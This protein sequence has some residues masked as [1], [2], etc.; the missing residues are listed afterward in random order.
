MLTGHAERGGL[1]A[2]FVAHLDVHGLGLHATAFHPA[3]VHAQKHVGPV[4]RLGAACS[5]VDGEEGGI[6]VEL[7]CEKLI[8]FEFLEIAHDGVVL[9]DDFRRGLSL[10]FR[11]SSAASSFRTSRSAARDSSCR[12]GWILLRSWRDFRDVAL[13][14]LAVIPEI[15]RRHA[16]FEFRELRCSVWVSQRNLRSSARRAETT[17]VSIDSRVADIDQ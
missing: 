13:C 8:E 2:G 4:A 11:A 10:V 5:G 7:A 15:G 1:D 12:K 3:R 9:L 16:R 17:E 6:V 14:V